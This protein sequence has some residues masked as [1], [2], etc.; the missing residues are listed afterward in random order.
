MHLKNTVAVSVP[1]KSKVFDY[2]LL[3]K[4]KL[5]LLVVFSSITGFL[6]APGPIEWQKVIFLILGGFLVTGSANAINQ[7]LERDYDKLMSRTQNRPVADNRMSVLE[8]LVIATIMGISGILILFWKLNFL[9]GVLGSL[10]LFI[11]A[12]IYTPLKRISPVAVFV[13]AFPGAVPP[14]LGYVAAT[15]K[16]GL[17]PGILFFIQFMWQFPHFWA[18]AWKLAD[19]YA[20]AGFYLLP[21]K[22]GKTKV[23]AFYILIYSIFMIPA[24]LLPWIFNISGWISAAIISLLGIY[25]VIKSIELYR[26]TEDKKALG[27]MFASFV[28]LPITQIIL[29]I[30][31]L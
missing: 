7:I 29:V 26:E 18:I 8:A 23:S 31:K 19:D 12:F 5:L 20:K 13:G 27:L 9:S 25:V 24:G 4:F 17:V 15:G 11:Y 21:S 22:S 1:L 30:D 10:A 3:I 16:F 6:M 2:G 28:Y 14:M